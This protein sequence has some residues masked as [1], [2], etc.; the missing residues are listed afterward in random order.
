MIRI[1]A[2]PL[3]RMPMAP[4]RPRNRRRTLGDIMSRLQSLTFAMLMLTALTGCQDALDSVSNKVEHPLPPK[5]VNKMKAAD[6]TRIFDV[7]VFNAALG[8]AFFSLS[9]GMG[10]MITYGSYLGK[11]DGIAGAAVWVLVTT[12]VIARDDTILAIRY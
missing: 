4:L 1:P 5:L 10:A 2:R 7:S 12:L 9:L 8:Q 6:L 11:R 3:N